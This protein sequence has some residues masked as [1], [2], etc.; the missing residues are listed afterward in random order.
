MGR[1]GQLVIGHIHRRFAEHGGDGLVEQFPVNA[2]HIV[3]VEQTQTL[4]PVNAQQLHQ[5]AAQALG[6]TVKAG[7]FFHVDTKYHMEIPPYFMAARARWPMSVRLC[8]LSN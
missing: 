3:A 7:L 2:L 6:L 1:G 5:L 4:Q 8:S